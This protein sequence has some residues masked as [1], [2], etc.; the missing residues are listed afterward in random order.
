MN[1]RKSRHGVRI[2]AS[3][4]LF[5]LVFVYLAY[6]TVAYLTRDHISLYEIGTPVSLSSD[7]TYT[8]LI[9]R[10]EEV[11]N[12]DTAGYLNYYVHEGSRVALNETVYSV[13]E[14]GRFSAMLSSAGSD[15]S[16][17]SSEELSSLTSMISNHTYHYDPSDFSSTYDLKGS[18]ETKLLKHLTSNTEQELEALGI[19]DALFHKYTADKTGIIA[20]Y[21]DG[22]EDLLPINVTED[23]FDRS[24]YKSTT[25]TGGSKVDAGAAAYK[26]VTSETWNIIIPLSGEDAEAYSEKTRLSV[27]FP[28][29]DLS[30]T[31]LF[32]EFRGA[33]GGIYGKMTLTR[34]MIQ[35]LDQRYLNVTVKSNAATGLKIPVSAITTAEFYRIP[36]DYLTQGGN[37]SS[38]GFQMEIDT[39]SGK[40]VQFISPAIVAKDD[41]FCYVSKDEI[42]L[43]TVLVK[44]DSA[45]KYTIAST[46]EL[47]GVYNVNK[48][49]AVFKIIDIIDRSGSYVIVTKGA[50]Y[51]VAVYDNILLDGSL[52]FEGK[53][54]YS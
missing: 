43:G 49:Y 33:D 53:M 10:S 42:T 25:Y 16:G 5:I 23:H 1:D 12:T 52:G 37:S 11:S 13:D 39:V 26:T 20:L 46:S 45:D 35:F 17:L 38:D 30:T 24:Q 51:S 6:H 28:S 54:I 4:L 8:G 15:S 40:S 44:P 2:S 14:T 7:R 47:E 31:V 50:S 27:E 19:D 3:V 9:I 34:Y 21:T 29:A 18:I 22:M 36:A 48:G 41:D 32:E